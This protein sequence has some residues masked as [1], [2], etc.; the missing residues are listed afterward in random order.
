MKI[1]ER[2]NRIPANATNGN[3]FFQKKEEAQEAGQRFFTKQPGVVPSIQTEPGDK[4]D[5]TAVQ[6]SGDPILEKT[7][8]NEAIV[9]KSSNAN[10][11]QVARIQS[12]LMQ[13]GIELPV[14]GADAMFGTETE[15]GVK[16]FQQKAGMSPKEW[17]GIVGRKTIGLLDRS[18]RN[19]TISTD[20]DKAENDLLLTDPK[21]KAEDDACKG[22]DTDKPC[23]DPNMVV[24][25]AADEAIAII[26]KV[27]DEQLPPVK[28][29]K[30]DYP[31]LFN[32]IFR[33][34]DTRDISFTVNEVRNIYGEI[35]KFIGRMKTDKSLVRC[36]T[37]CD[38]GCRS[39]SPAYHSGNATAGTHIITFCPDFEQHKDRIMIVLHE[40]HHASIPGSSDKAYADTRLFDKLDHS[41][42]LLNAA[43]FHVYAG[44][45]DKPGSQPVGPEVKDTN[46][47]ND[48]SR[49]NNV[50][51]VLA[52]LEQWFRLVPFDVSQTVQGV[53]EAKEKGHY[54]KNNPRI[55]MERVFSK[56]FGL[57]S[58]PAAPNEKDVKTLQAINERVELM[59]KAFSDPFIILE[60][61]GES[62]W[63]EGPGT[64]LALNQ[65]LTGLDANHM[66]IAL[67]QELIHATPNISAESE[68]LY[69]GAI[70]DLR[71]FRELDP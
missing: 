64:D 38:G 46:L 16:D 23:A 5:L 13:L 71:N 56:W 29:K 22:K 33:N 25:K 48:T 11:D 55:F 63:S 8:D 7:F 42:A 45:V 34:N 27:L 49:K 59:E 41:K 15:N 9:G 66:I 32:R 30:A 50:N 52:F 31:D 28:N 14:F 51:M 44:W 6:L 36:A 69:A 39:G 61:S 35:K 65:Q 53:E 3:A 47:L 37:E 67:L 68:P 18:V 58:P 4:H 21:K 40:S 20:T 19:N 26:D 12:A 57:T 62:F 70:N 2:K 1:Q 17:D 60:T 24:N 54:T 10:G 43:S